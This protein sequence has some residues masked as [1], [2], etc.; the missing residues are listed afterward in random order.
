MWRNNSEPYV[1]RLRGVVR[2]RNMVAKLRG[3]E[4]NACGASA[5]F[6]PD[7]LSA[8][9]DDFSAMKFMMQAGHVRSLRS[10]NLQFMTRRVAPCGV[11]EAL[12]KGMNIIHILHVDERDR[13]KTT[14]PAK[15]RAAAKQASI[16]PSL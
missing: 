2:A 8:R 9:M 10:A 4:F 16:A 11:N 1:R 7:E 12:M 13:E 15:E 3:S 5:R 14:T 6:P